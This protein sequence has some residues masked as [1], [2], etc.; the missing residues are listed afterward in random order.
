MTLYQVLVPLTPVLTITANVV[1]LFYTIPA[2]K[3]TGN[4][5]FL[6]LGFAALLGTFDTVC[7][8]TIG[9]D[10]HRKAHSDYLTYRALRKLTYCA[11]CAFGATGIVLLA[12]AAVRGKGDGSDAASNHTPKQP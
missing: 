5:A 1:V 3:R 9:L 2:F 7:D 8:Y 4:R 10:L 11:D 6:W 12:R